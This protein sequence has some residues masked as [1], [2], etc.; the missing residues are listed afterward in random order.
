MREQLS[1][2]EKGA[3][4]R[5]QD[6]GL[7]QYWKATFFEVDEDG[8]RKVGPAEV[9]HVVDLETL[10]TMRPRSVAHT[11]FLFLHNHP[12]VPEVHVSDYEIE[13]VRLA[14]PSVAGGSRDER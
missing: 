8:N 6:E 1:A 4:Q 2:Q 5:A 10:P 3:L 13:R 12:D 7:R 9:A 14:P 11:A